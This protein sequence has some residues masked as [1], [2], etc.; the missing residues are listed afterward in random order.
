MIAFENMTR[1]Q[2]KD[3]LYNLEIDNC[4][5]ILS[6]IQQVTTID[7]MSYDDLKEALKDFVE[8][9]Y[10]DNATSVLNVL[11]EMQSY[12]MQSCYYV[13]PF[14]ET[15]CKR[16]KLLTDEI[17]LYHFMFHTFND[18]EIVKILNKSIELGAIYE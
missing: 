6:S 5:E 11:W 10:F 18:D 15:F 2:L 14:D 13:R 1:E 16:G 8:W 3:F 7:V 4:N 9:E 12:H 17:D